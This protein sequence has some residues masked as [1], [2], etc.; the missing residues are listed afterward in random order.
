M[1][2]QF[3]DYVGGQQVQQHGERGSDPFAS[4]DAATQGNAHRQ[5]QAQDAAMGKLNIAQAHQPRT[6]GLLPREADLR[7][8]C[9]KLAAD[10]V[11][12]HDVVRYAGEL[13]A[14]VLGQ[15]QQKA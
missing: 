1:G 3:T 13:V 9:V 15:D 12:S 5:T 8:Q 11:P 6:A 14:Y 2:E 10:K 4:Y 7:L